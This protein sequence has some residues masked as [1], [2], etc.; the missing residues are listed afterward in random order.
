MRDTGCA[1][2]GMQFGKRGIK[3]PTNIAGIFSHYSDFNAELSEQLY[4][5]RILIACLFCKQV[6]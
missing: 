5:Q 3:A 4:L 1:V 6:S 2:C